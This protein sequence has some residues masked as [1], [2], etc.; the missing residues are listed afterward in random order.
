MRF[1]IGF[2]AGVACTLIA[3]K[4]RATIAREVADV[5]EVLDLTLDA[6]RVHL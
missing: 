1:A 6:F 5:G 2:F 4:V 3:L